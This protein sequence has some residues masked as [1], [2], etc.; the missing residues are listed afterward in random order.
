[1]RAVYEGFRESK[2]KMAE[3]YVKGIWPPVVAQKVAILADPLRQ[4]GD[5]HGHV[6]EMS[7][8]EQTPIPAIT[9]SKNIPSKNL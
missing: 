8:S 7:S 3:Q 4:P 5:H 2:D 6:V 9:R 1:V